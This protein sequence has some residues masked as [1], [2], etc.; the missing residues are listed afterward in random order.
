MLFRS[1]VHAWPS[2]LQIH[3]PNF[4]FESA[5]ANLSA[6]NPVVNRLPFV[7]RKSAAAGYALQ[8]EA[9]NTASS[10]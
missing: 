10:L 4:Q 6:D 2:Q 1:T 3:I 5:T 9:H 8:I 7:A